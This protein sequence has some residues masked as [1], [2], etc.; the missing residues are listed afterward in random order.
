MVSPL[1]LGPPAKTAGAE[2]SPFSSLWI[3]SNALKLIVS[4]QI[5]GR[6]LKDN[7]VPDKVE[8]GS[9]EFTSSEKTDDAE[10]GHHYA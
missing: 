4:P 5:V 8:T 3:N 1:D 6:D 7:L 2:F 9:S 10:S